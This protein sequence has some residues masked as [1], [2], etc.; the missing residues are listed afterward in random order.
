MYRYRM[1]FLFSDESRR[2]TNMNE[3]RPVYDCRLIGSCGATR[4]ISRLGRQARCDTRHAR[5]HL[6]ILVVSVLY[7]INVAPSLV[8]RYGSLT[9]NYSSNRTGILQ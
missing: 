3:S 1:W 9:G 6:V 4:L 5:H 2:T 8:Y 7:C